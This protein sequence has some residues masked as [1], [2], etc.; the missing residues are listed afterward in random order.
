MSRETIAV[1]NPYT[2]QEIGQVPRGTEDDI[3]QAVQ[4]A[5]KGARLMR[6][7]PLHQRARL[8]A[9]IASRM[10]QS[11]EELAR[12]LV[13]E[14]GKTIREA[15]AEALRAAT[16]FQ[17]TAEETRRLH[18]ETLPFDALPNGEGRT[19]FWTREPVGIVG[20]ITPWNVPLALASHKVAPALGAGNAVVLKPAEQTPLHALRLREIAREAG[21]P[22]DAFQVVTG[23]GEEA[24]DALVRHPEVALLTFTGSREVGMQLP[25]RAGFKRVT[26]ELGGNSPVLVT[27]SAAL[28][29]AAEA[30]VR[31]GFAVAGQLCISVQRVLVQES[32]QEALLAE[33]LPRVRALR[34]GDPAEET[35]DVGALISREACDRIEQEV[36]EAQR[37]GAVARIGGERLGESLYAP[38]VLENVGRAARLACEEAFAPLLLIMPYATIEEAVELANATPYGLNAGI[39]TNDLREAWFAAREMIAGSVMVNDVPTFRSDLMPYGGRK[40]SGLGREGVRFTLEEMTATKVVCFRL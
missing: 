10:E 27:P 16:L 40:Q 30:I 8:L 36:R 3:A 28:S 9:A 23:Y 31:G 24:G 5:Q 26:L 25:G 19:G 18:G 35:T 2:Q 22:E 37:A 12:V 32:V 33:I 14:T 13:A 21:I 7:M 4:R 38:T 1:F 39:Y 15:R 20:A 11:A 17:L 29:E 34:V 6:A